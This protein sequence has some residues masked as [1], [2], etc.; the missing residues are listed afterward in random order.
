[1]HNIDGG[2]AFTLNLEQLLVLT[3]KGT[4]IAHFI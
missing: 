2:Q 3:Y 1:M 4:K